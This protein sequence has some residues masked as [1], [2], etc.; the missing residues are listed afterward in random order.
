MDRPAGRPAV[1][2]NDDRSAV[3]NEQGKI[4]IYTTVYNTRPYVAQCVESVL[5]QTYTNFEFIILDNGCTDGSSEI[6]REFASRDERIRLIRREENQYGFITNIILTEGDGAYITILDSDDWLEPSYLERLVALAVKNDLDIACTGSYKNDERT[7]EE[8]PYQRRRKQ[9]L[10]VRPT[11]FQTAFMQYSPYLDALWGKL[12]RTEVAR[13]AFGIPCIYST[14]AM[15]TLICFRMLRLSNGI[16]IDNSTLHHYRIRAGS[17]ATTYQ[18][19]RFDGVV[20]F[21]TNLMDFL[22]DF[23][24][25]LPPNMAFLHGLYVN[26]VVS[27]LDLALR[28]GLPLPDK[29]S[30][31]LRILGHPQTQ[32]ILRQRAESELDYPIARLLRGLLDTL[33]NSGLSQEELEQA[34]P[35][36]QAV[37]QAAA[38]RCCPAVTTASMGLFLEDQSAVRAQMGERRLYPFYIAHH[39]T[40]LLLFGSR[41]PLRFL[42]G[43]AV[44][45]MQLLA[46]DDPEAMLQRLRRL[47]RNKRLAERYA[48][49]E[50]IGLLEQSL[51]GGER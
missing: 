26:N 30:E 3:V 5:R 14:W 19:T 28:S 32:E 27:A 44:P 36:V 43:N 2:Q 21:H 49:A 50:A 31:Y 20:Y 25:V 51:K 1:S 47:A 24:P 33:L 13:E 7:G 35:Q 10:L 23:G 8:T 39:R 16:G 45:L 6:L 29:L 15:D 46:A 38:P 42:P 11:E 12:V 4:S 17:I 9:P 41:S 18:P 40:F 37:L 34:Y 48:L 22:S